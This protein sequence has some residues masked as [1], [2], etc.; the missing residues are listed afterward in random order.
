MNLTVLSDNQ[1]LTM[2]S[3]DIAEL[4]GKEHKNVIRDIRVMLDEL[5]DG[6]DLSH[7]MRPIITEQKDARGY[8]TQFNLPKRECLILISGYSILLRSKIIDRWQELEQSS[9]LPNVQQKTFLHPLEITSAISLAVLPVLKSYGIDH[10]SAVI[11]ANRTAKEAT[12]YD[13]L[14]LG[15]VQLEAPNQ[16]YLP[17]TATELGNIKGITANKMNKLLAENDFQFKVGKD[18]T[19]TEKAKGFF[20]LLD[21]G[22]KHSN[23]TPVTHLK[24]YESVLAELQE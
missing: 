10:N 7:D 15:N 2:S 23:G 24:W 14:A 17:L 1:Q 16:K 19:P 3:L 13:I 21:I 4:T 5:K 18:W 12:G 8:T 11:S 20:K 6:S 9:T 22:K